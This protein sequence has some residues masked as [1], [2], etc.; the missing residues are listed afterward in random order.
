MAAL[1][2]EDILQWADGTWCYACEISEMSH[3]SDDYERIPEDTDAYKTPRAQ[4]YRGGQFRDG[5]FRDGQ[6]E[7][8][9]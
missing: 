9:F 6:F 8:E 4:E 7:L 5:Q 3:M 2:G 1:S